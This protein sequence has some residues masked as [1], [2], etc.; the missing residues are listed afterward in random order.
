MGY[1]GGLV[2]GGNTQLSAAGVEYGGF[3]SMKTEN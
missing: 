1:R 3:F 2:F